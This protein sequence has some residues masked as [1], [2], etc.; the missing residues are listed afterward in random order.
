[1]VGVYDGVAAAAGAAC[2][3]S[4]VGRCPP[5]DG[6]VAAMGGVKFCCWPT[7]DAAPCV[8]ASVPAEIG[9]PDCIPFVKLFAR[10]SGESP[11]G[12]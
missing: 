1:M 3:V 12:G 8:S 7:G 11:C 2:A 6:V 10:L 4:N 9:E 5:L